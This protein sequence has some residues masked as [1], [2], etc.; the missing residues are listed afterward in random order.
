M[1]TATDLN[2]LSELAKLL[3]ADGWCIH[4]YEVIASN[5]VKLTI[6]QKEKGAANVPE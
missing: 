3:A 2:T 4:E 6:V 1:K 5:T